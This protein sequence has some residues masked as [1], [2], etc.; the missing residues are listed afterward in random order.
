MHVLFNRRSNGRKEKCKRDNCGSG[1][2]S[3]R[4]SI[5]SKA[6]TRRQVCRLEMALA[7]P[8]SPG[9]PDRL[10]ISSAWARMVDGYHKKKP[11]AYAG[12]AGSTWRRREMAR[13]TASY[14][15]ALA[16]TRR[17]GYEDHESNR[18]NYPPSRHPPRSCIARL[19]PARQLSAYFTVL[20]WKYSRLLDSRGN[21]HLQFYWVGK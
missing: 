1:Q 10:S 14:T 21:S 6:T 11:R 17:R 19:D 2:H 12:A 18:R 16:R 9:R 5:A 13:G 4:T 8:S 15:A 7:A 20:S 3:F